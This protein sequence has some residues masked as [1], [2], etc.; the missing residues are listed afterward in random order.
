MDQ[1][2]VCFPVQTQAD[3]WGLA[4][5]LEHLR[6]DLG[7]SWA[8]INQYR[9]ALRSVCRAGWLGNP[10]EDFPFLED[11][12]EGIKKRSPKTPTRKE[13]I[14]AQVVTAL[15]NFWEAS[16]RRYRER[17]QHREA[18][19]VLRHQVSVILGFTAMSRKSE[20]FLSADG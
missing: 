11:F 7:H 5:F 15:L 6:R 17:G 16:E 2:R 19:T 4:M 9:T 18:D 12:C 13:G 1:G 8:Y 14:T 20:I 3:A 10:F